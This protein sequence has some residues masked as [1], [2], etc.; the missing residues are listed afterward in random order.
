[1]YLNDL[2]RFDPDGST[3]G[4]SGSWTEIIGYG[5]WKREGAAVFVIENKAYICNGKTSY[6]V[7]DFWVFDPDGALAGNPL[8]SQKRTMAN[9]NQEEDYDDDYGG[10]ARS[11]GVAYVVDVAGQPRGHIV[12]GSKNSNWEYDHDN[13]LWTQRTKFWNHGQGNAREGMVSF[14]FPATG[15]AYVGMGRSG[16][17]S[18]YDDL[19]EFFPLLEDDPYQD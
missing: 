3:S 14:S 11:Y 8:W 16:T 15:K 19:W 17:V 1:M 9:S 7:T 2:W 10:L 13:D 6:D 18:D 4:L 5:G 12:G